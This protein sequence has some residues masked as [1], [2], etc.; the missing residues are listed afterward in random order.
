MEI[1]EITNL[2]LSIPK[3]EE[4]ANLNVFSVVS[5]YTGDIL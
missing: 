1:K 5:N 2:D 4:R 3:I